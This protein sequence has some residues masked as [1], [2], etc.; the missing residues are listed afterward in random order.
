MKQKKLRIGFIGLGLMG[1]PMAKNI[2]KAGFPLKVY[3]RTKEKTKNFVKLG[4]NSASTPSNLAQ[5][6]DVVIT[7]VTAAKD[8]EA[9]LFGKNGVVEKAKKGLTV[10]DMS[11][12]G[13]SA[14]KKIAQKLSNFQIDFIDA[15]VTGSTPKAITGELTIF[16]GG[17]EDIF[18][19]AKPVLSAMGANIHYM[20]PVGS[21][22]AIK[23]INNHLIATSIV[24][25]AEGILLA[26]TMGLSRKKAGEVLKTV[27]AMSGF[28]N[29]RLPNFVNN[30]Y[31]L[32]FS[33]ANMRKDLLLAMG[34]A[35][36]GK[37][38]LPTLTTIVKLYDKAMKQGLAEQD[39]SEVI[40]IL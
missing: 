16:V 30:K 8:V 2:L 19:K 40:K 10:I 28:M 20:G 38:A 22:Q 5:D 36:K 27:P 4:V 29:L 6:V 1:N 12:V 24:A 31:P 39:M 18:N 37:R 34:E 32:L 33:T 17:K 13:P 3:N 23:L 7:M 25:L 21:G 35:N 26:D 9:V 14:A 11:T 15:P